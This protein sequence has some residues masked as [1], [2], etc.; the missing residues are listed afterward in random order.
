MLEKS[1]S[2]PGQQTNPYFTYYFLL[3]TTHNLYKRI[4]ANMAGEQKH[5]VYDDGRDILLSLYMALIPVTVRWDGLSTSGTGTG[6]YDRRIQPRT[7]HISIP[8]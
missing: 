2:T 5:P 1:N 7:L 3:L 4:L 6:V 8:Q